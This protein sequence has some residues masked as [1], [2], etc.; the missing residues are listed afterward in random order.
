M[1]KPNLVYANANCTTKPEVIKTL[2]QLMKNSGKEVLI[3]E[4]SASHADIARV[5]NAFVDLVAVLPD[6]L[7]KG[8][9]KGLVGEDDAVASV[10]HRNETR[11]IVENR[12]AEARLQA[13][14][15]L[16]HG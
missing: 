7:A 4:G 16:V 3:G 8:L 9:D 13:V 15:G 11:R 10:E 2:A 14:G 5:L 6:T 1:L 12:Q